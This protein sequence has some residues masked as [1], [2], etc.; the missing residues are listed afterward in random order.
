MDST[1]L[2]KSKLQNWC[3]C[4]CCHC[5][6]LPMEFSQFAKVRVSELVLSPLLPLPSLPMEQRPCQSQSFRIGA[7]TCCH[8]HALP[9]E[10]V[11][12]PSQIFSAPQ[13]EHQAV[14][15]S[16]RRCEVRSTCAICM[17]LSSPPS[18]RAT[19]PWPRG[20]P[21]YVLST[22]ATYAVKGL[23]II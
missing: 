23:F 21:D 5:H 2:P 14:R 8:C 1:L 17:L 16:R 20:A 4:H 11:P 15:I 22:L 9:M 12:C 7:H 13:M 19:P 10:S 18:D 6:A 3:D